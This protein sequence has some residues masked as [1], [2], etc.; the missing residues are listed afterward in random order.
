MVLASIRA[1]VVLPTPRGPQNRNACASWLFLIAIIKVVVICYCHTTVE[2]FWG[3]YFL[4]ETI[5][6]SI[7]A[8]KLSEKNFYS[9]AQ[10]RHP[11]KKV[12]AA[13]GQEK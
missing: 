4:A 3:L 1:Q 6:L 13:P 12:L 9:G 5:N 7:P 10:N 11:Y 2:K 8:A